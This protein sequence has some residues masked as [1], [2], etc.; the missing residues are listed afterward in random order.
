MLSDLANFLTPDETFGDLLARCHSEPLALGV[1][2]L[3]ELVPVRASQLIEISGASGSG[4][5]ELL[6]QA[7]A[8][9]I[10]PK[11]SGL[12]LGRGEHA[13]YLDLDGKFDLIR[14]MQV[15]QGR[16]RAA[17]PEANQQGVELPDDVLR[18]SL[19]RFHLI[20][21]HSSFDYLAALWTLRNLIPIL[22]EAEGCQLL[23]LDNVAAFYWLDRIC[24]PT[25]SA[26]PGPRADLSGQGGVL[27]LQSVH[28]AAGQMLKDL[29]RTH[30]LVCLATRHNI[31]TSQGDADGW[32]YH[33]FM[34]QPWQALV[35]HK[36]LLKSV[37]GSWTSQG[38]S[39]LFQGI[40]QARP[41]RVLTLDIGAATAS[42]G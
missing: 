33:D 5:T 19:Q 18:P 10:L 25:P 22:Q 23:L 26:P 32:H 8:A 9:A 3:E 39:T 4:K 15:L 38:R 14:L 28:A 29:M 34:P 31:L 16:L 11:V 1:R 20:Q 12:D 35:R 27:T 2:F 21:C 7:A 42:A 36:V 6:T 30:R 41:D 37:P 24:Q 17:E 40:N 13:I